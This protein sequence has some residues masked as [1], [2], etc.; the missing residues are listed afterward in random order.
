MTADAPA[1][2]DE[3]K[4]SW[5]T[6]IRK[7]TWRYLLRRTLHE[8]GQDGGI[9]AAAALTFFAVLSVFPAALAIVSLIGVVGD[10]PDVVTRLLKLLD[11]VAPGAV[12]DVLRGPL[13][14]IASTS[15]AN[16]TLA[17]GLVAALWS[18]STYVSAFGRA[19]NRIYEVDEGRPFWKRKPAQLAVTILLI[20]LVV[21]IAGIV[22]L[23]G[24]ILRAVGDALNIGD[25]A[26]AVWDIGKWP[27]LVISV[28]LI[29]AVLYA[30]TP[31]IRQPKFRWLS[32]GAG[33]AILLLGAAS[34]GFAFYVS[35]FGT[36]NQTFG[37][38]A[39]VII[40][41]I[42]VFLVNVALLLGAEFNTELERGRQLQAGIAAEVR[43]QL[44]PRDTTSSDLAHQTAEVD[45]EHGLLLRKGE[46]LPPRTDTLVARARDG[47]TS[48]WDRI[49]KRS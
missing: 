48:I 3:T 37:A 22:V 45:E 47:I 24:P 16:L 39:G 34:G 42:W 5:P 29:V 10:G 21:L 25:G 35:N 38:L 26:V 18:A 7:R 33:L 31:N 44:P 46:A 23:S 9:D 32:L 28:V 19:L 40:F 49:W 2:D 12:T 6:Q 1:P 30:T 20:I 41:L 13:D 15:S 36:Y 11:Q 8:F 4:V 43:L 27:V 17:V 14:E